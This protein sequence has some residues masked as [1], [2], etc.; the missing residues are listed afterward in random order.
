MKNAH[1]FPGLVVLAVLVGLPGCS[2]TPKEPTVQTKS[3]KVIPAQL[4]AQANRSYAERWLQRVEGAAN[5]VGRTTEDVEIRRRTVLWKIS[6]LT[7]IDVALSLDD[8]RF[9]LLQLWTNT[10]QARNYIRERG[11]RV[12]GDAGQ[13]IALE[14]MED[15]VELVTHVAEQFFPEKL[16]P[17]ARAEVEKF[18]EKNPVLEIDP[19]AVAD[20]RATLLPGLLSFSW[21]K[22]ITQPLNIGGGVAD[23]AVSISEVARSVD[24]IST[25]IGALPMMTRWQTELLLFDLNEND[26]VMSLR[27]NIDETSKS[28]AA[29]IETT[30]RLPGEIQEQVSKTLKEVE[31]GQGELRKTLVEARAVVSDAKDAVTEVNAAL[32]KTE[33]IVGDLEKVTTSF[34]EA[35]AAWEPTLKELRAIT[36]DSTPPEET[37]PGPPAEED[38]GPNEDIAN[39]VLLVDGARDTAVEL[40]G[41]LSELRTTLASGDIEQVM[42]GVDGTARGT[43]D[44]ATARMEDVVDY[45]AWRGLMLAFGI[46]VIALA[47]RFTANRFLP[48][49]A[50]KES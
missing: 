39:L 2:S 36:G 26:T 32:G 6:T 5:R 31:E 33:E 18:A 8:A 37:P 48:K 25:T 44:H 7:T 41:L 12:F 17:E 34:A 24:G 11:A 16:F 23:T 22:E 4:L 20:E 3:G 29:L 14:A 47:Y 50:P 1:L 46:A 35:G 40:K 28:I 38:S 10:L 19:R 15:M 13:P 42:D 49:P 9:A 45:A 43:V 30:N 27:K 21:V